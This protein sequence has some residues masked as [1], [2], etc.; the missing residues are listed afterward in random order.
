LRR[1]RRSL[2]AWGIAG[3]EDFDGVES[4]QR[5]WAKNVRAEAEKAPPTGPE[6]IWD[7]VFA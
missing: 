6:S 7:H 3:H 5:A 2:S 1:Y 4:E